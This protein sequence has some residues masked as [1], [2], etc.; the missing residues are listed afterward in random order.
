[1]QQAAIRNVD[2]HGLEVSPTGDPHGLVVGHD[3]YRVSLMLGKRLVN[4]LT[5]DPAQAR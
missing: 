5:H 1:M 2:L 3:E 4:Y